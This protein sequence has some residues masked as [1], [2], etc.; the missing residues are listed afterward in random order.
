MSDKG[1]I[2][3]VI[4]DDFMSLEEEKAEIKSNVQ[5]KEDFRKLKKEFNIR[6]VLT[7]F[8]LK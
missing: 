3:K 6:D 7:Q 4:V 1:E 2:Q 8:V 5:E